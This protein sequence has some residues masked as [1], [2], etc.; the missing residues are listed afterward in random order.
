[1]II[2]PTSEPQLSFL[3]IILALKHHKLASPLSLGIW[4][5][6]TPD[7]FNSTLN[8]LAPWSD[9]WIPLTL[10]RVIVRDIGAERLFWD[11]KGRGLL[12]DV[13]DA[14]SWEEDGGW[15]HKYVHTI[16]G[17]ANVKLATC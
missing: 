7:T 14:V 3:S 2:S 10:A 5:N 4:Y 12:G 1:L 9:I 8:G 16:G 6:P 15:S 13:D 11:K 17:H